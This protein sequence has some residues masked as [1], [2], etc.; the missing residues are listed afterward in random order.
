MT[1]YRW[2]SAWGYELLPV[3]AILSLVRF[4][5]VVTVDAKYVLVP[6]NDKAEG[7]MRHWMY[8]YLAVGVHTYDALH[9]AIYVHNTRE[10]AHVFLL[11]LCA[12]GYQPQAIVTDL[13]RLWP[14]H[15]PGVSQS[16]APR[17]PVARRT[18]D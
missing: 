5:G 11:A 18:G 14:G 2:V 8:V 1:V 9:I 7:K 4:S 16:P 6:K 17:M 15:C 10:S 13:L 12:K 3:V